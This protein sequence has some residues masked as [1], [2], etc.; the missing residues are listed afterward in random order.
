VFD[1]VLVH[2][3]RRDGRMRELKVEEEREVIDGSW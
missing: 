1:A 3:T 2:H